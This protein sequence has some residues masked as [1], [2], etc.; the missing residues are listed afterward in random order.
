MYFRYDHC[1]SSFSQSIGPFGGGLPYVPLYGENAVITERAGSHNRLTSLENGGNLDNLF[2]S[3]SLTSKSPS[4]VPTSIHAPKEEVL[5]SLLS[6]YCVSVFHDFLVPI[7][8]LNMTTYLPRFIFGTNFHN[9]LLYL[10]LIL[11]RK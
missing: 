6:V 10:L 9:Y 5:Y 2:S 1:C 7:V 8:L 4:T 11:L 3:T